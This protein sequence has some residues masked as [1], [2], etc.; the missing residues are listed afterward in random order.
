MQGFTYIETDLKQAPFSFLNNLFWRQN[1]ELKSVDGEKILRHELVHIKQ[2]HTYDKLFSQTIAC[3]FW[4]NPFYWLI[5]KELTVL[6]EFIADAGSIEEGD[7]A[8]FAKMLLQ[9]HN[10]GRYLNATH[11]FF[12]SSIKRRLVMISLS[13]NVR[14]SYLRR[15]LVLPVIVAVVIFSSVSIVRAQHDPRLNPNDTVNIKN[16]SLEKRNDS[17]V[18][19]KVNYV[20]ARGKTAVLN[21]AAKY[22]ET[23]SLKG[24][25]SSKAFI[26]DDETGETKEIGHA[27]VR[28]IV[29]QI[30][31]GPPSDEIY[32]V[33]GTEWPSE[34]SQK[35]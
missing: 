23:D 5:Q 32:F 21:I 17:I 4:A 2:G 9:A 13:R 35:T 22:S 30:I 34:S 25:N 8:S 11:L 1:I 10:G 26:H 7:T 24:D 15:V 20:D 18:D 27:Q 16:I 19:V 28:E 14:H 12:N 6:H 29:K 33:D 31:Q 3:M